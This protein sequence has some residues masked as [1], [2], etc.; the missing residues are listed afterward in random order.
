M[1]PI[2]N[3]PNREGQDPHELPRRTAGEQQM[4]SEFLQPNAVSHI[5]DTCNG[6]ACYDFTFSGP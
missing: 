1:P 6:A 4:V 5:T 3:V 2:P